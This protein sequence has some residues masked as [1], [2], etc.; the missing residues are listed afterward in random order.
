MKDAT[1]AKL[2]DRKAKVKCEFDALAAKHSET[3]GRIKELES[4]ILKIESSILKVQGAHAELES[5]LA[6]EPPKAGQ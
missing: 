2:E 4:E 6:E 5:L 3:L 1:R